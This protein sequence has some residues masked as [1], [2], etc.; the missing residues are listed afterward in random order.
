MVLRLNF[1][2]MEQ[3]GRPELSKNREAKDL[4]D[5]KARVCRA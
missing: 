1:S 2:E 3:N 4:P 5:K